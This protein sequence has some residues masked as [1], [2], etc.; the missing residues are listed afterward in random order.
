ADRA[1][2]TIR[3]FTVSVGLAVIVMTLAVGAP[4]GWVFRAGW[5]AHAEILRL[6]LNNARLEIENSGYRATASGL[7]GDIASLQAVIDDL[8]ARTPLD[9][10]RVRASV[11]RL[12]A[13]LAA[14]LRPDASIPVAGQTFGNLRYLLESL[15]RE[16]QIVRRGVALREALAEATPTLWP[17]NGW[18][19][20]GYGYRRDP[21]TGRRDHHPAIDIS[22][23]PGEPVY[24]TGAGL[25]AEAKRNGA[26][27]NLVEI[28]HGFGLLTRYG[29]LS[30]F[31][32][33][34]GDTVQRGDLIGYAGAT[35]RATGN[36]VH[37]EIW[38]HG[39]T[40]NPLRL[41]SPTDVLAA[42]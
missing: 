9:V 23:R 5:D 17:V 11:E 4:L 12:P 3:R 42:N 31:A 2:G 7:I 19:S 39:R 18:V 37:Y 1:T 33:R 36:H 8:A 10:V 14:S 27:G 22:T 13:S 34:P 28:S 29:H 38:V 32:V 21:F 26:Y 41:I 25:V 15:N 16:L 40:I 6:R 30:T 35:G 24:A 20:A